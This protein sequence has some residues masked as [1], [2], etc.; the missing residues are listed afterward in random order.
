M[1]LNSVCAFHSAGWRQSLRATYGYLIVDSVGKSHEE[2]EGGGVEFGSVE[3]WLTGRRLVSLPFADHCEPLV[4]G[5][6]GVVALVDWIREEYKRGRWRYIEL[7]PINS[8][9]F[10]GTELT[11]SRSYWLHMLSLEPSI[12]ALFRNLDK[13]CLQRRIRHA[14]REKLIYR[15]GTTPDML[16]AFY[17]LLLKTRRRQSLLPQPRKWFENLLRFMG[18]EAEIRL[19]IKN[20]TPVGALFTLRHGDSVIYKYGCSDE[21]F[22]PMGAMPFLFWHLIEESKGEGAAWIDFG[23]T[24]LNQVG[25]LTFK[26]HFGGRR[27]RLTYLRYPPEA[28]ATVEVPSEMRFA[29]RI[30]HLLPDGAST[31]LGGLAYRH[32]G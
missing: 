17:R 21:R 29:R 4:D 6:E 7:R 8:D 32:F 13:N 11:P 31:V 1:K 9:R 24:D 19:A 20:T 2:F 12:E 28:E 18:P 23:R 5:R 16:D 14:G 25:L 30:F 26:D 27:Q 15:R 22:H 3:S 10:A